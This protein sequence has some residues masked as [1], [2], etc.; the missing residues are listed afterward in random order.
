EQRQSQSPGALCAALGKR[1]ANNGQSSSTW[2]LSNINDGAS[3]EPPA[4]WRARRKE[5]GLD[6]RRMVQIVVCSR[7]GDRSGRRQA[8]AAGCPHAER[9][10]SRHSRVLVGG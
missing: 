9:R 8:D 2:S 6:A 10:C 5:K 1:S 7:T 3:E 4:N